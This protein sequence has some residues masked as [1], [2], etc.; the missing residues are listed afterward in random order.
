MLLLLHPSHQTLSPKDRRKKKKRK[1]RII[2][3]QVTTNA[4]S[5]SLSLPQNTPAKTTPPHRQ[6]DTEPTLHQTSTEQQ[7]PNPP[8][9]TQNPPKR[10][11]LIQILQQ[12]IHHPRQIPINILLLDLDGSSQATLAIGPVPSSSSLFTTTTAAATA[13][14]DLGKLARTA[15]EQGRFLAGVGFGD[16]GRLGGEVKVQELGQTELD[17]ATGFFG[18]EERGDGQEAVEIFKDARVLGTVEE[19]DD[20]GDDGG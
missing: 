17:L 5:L 1:H 4:L 14:K 8:P 12:L 13:T 6:T 2:H 18:L 9:S 20:E 7:Q 3:S 10:L 11:I 19:G 16:G 15:R